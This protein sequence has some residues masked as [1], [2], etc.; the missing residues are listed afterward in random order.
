M[1]IDII[2]IITAIFTTITVMINLSRLQA[3]LHTILTT[4]PPPLL[5]SSLCSSDHDCSIIAKT[6]TNNIIGIAN[7]MMVI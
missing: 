3:A 7:I 4:S 6:I 1:T 5:P 2:T